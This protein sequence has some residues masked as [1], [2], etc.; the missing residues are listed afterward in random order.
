MN[1]F[2][3]VFI[4]FRHCNNFISCCPGCVTVCARSYGGHDI[5]EETVGAWG[6]AGVLWQACGWQWSELVVWSAPYGDRGEVGRGYGWNVLASENRWRDGKSYLGNSVTAFNI[7]PFLLLS[8]PPPP[9]T[10]TTTTMTTIITTTNNNIATT[11]TTITT[12]TATT[13]TTTTMTL[14]IATTTTTTTIIIG[15]RGGTVGWG[16]VLQVGWSWVWFPMV[17]LEFFIDI[18]LLAA[19]WPWGWLSL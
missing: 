1:L 10:T 19:L 3:L 2:I 17:S 12:T 9:P 13:T 11:T 14:I 18:I 16:T 15:A 6:P 4:H 5:H 8:P 7:L